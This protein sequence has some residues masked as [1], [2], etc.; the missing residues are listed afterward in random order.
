M[1]LMMQRECVVIF[2]WVSCM[3]FVF[4]FACSDHRLEKQQDINSGAYPKLVVSPLEVDFGVF[5]S[6]TVF[7]EIT[8]E[9]QGNGRLQVEPEIISDSKFSFL[10]NPPPSS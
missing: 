1:V 4:V 2:Y 10:P 8:I 6:S 9:N 7:R 3:L 5:D